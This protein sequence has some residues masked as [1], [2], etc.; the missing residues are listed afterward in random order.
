[1]ECLHKTYRQ[2]RQEMASRLFVENTIDNVVHTAAYAKTDYIRDVRVSINVRG[3][4]LPL[5]G[6]HRISKRPST[7]NIKNDYFTPEEEEADRWGTS[8]VGVCLNELLNDA[9]IGAV[10]NSKHDRLDNSDKRITKKFIQTNSHSTGL[11]DDL[12]PFTLG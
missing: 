10:K 6:K 4:L 3:S 12:P 2:G 8:G 9:F 7:I 11:P 1:M 5:P